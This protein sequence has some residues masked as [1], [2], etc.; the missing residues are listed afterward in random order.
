MIATVPLNGAVAVP[1]NQ[2]L[3]ATFSIPMNA[4]TLTTPGTFILAVGPVPGGANVPGAVVYDS[5]SNS[6]IFSPTAAL[7]ATTQYTATITTAAQS[8]QGNG[9]AAN[10]NWTFTTGAA[11]NAIPPTVIT[12]KSIGRRSERAAQSKNRRHIQHAMNPATISAAG[13]F[14]LAVTAGGAAVLGTVTYSGNTAVFSPAA[15]L[16]PSTQY[17]A[18]ITT[19]AK[20]LTGVAMAANDV[21]SFTTGLTANAGAPTV[22]ATVPAS[23]ATAVPL[24]QKIS[25]TFSTAMNPGSIMAAGTFTVAV[26]GVGG[27]NVPGTVAYA[28]NTAVFTPNANLAASTLYT[29]TIT[30]AAQN[31]TGTPMGGQLHM[32][33]HH[34]RRRK[35]RCAHN[36]RYKSS[37]RRD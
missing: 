3:S 25:A 2:K 33:F 12:Y 18:T 27:A 34:W 9:L 21:W 28:G 8:T 36:H 7:T 11:A 22:I 37:Q 15:N 5:S 19:A 6:A 17:T 10:F 31:L 23:G 26:A 35:C 1:L 16:S 20:D 32:E 24:N 14:T 4:A 13:T 29:A 30:I